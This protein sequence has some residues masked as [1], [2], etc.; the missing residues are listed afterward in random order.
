MGRSTSLDHTF[1]SNVARFIPRSMPVASMA[2]G[3]RG[4]VGVRRRKHPP[5][6]RSTSVGL[7]FE[8]A[9][10]IDDC[11]APA[12]NVRPGAVADAIPRTGYVDYVA[13]ASGCRH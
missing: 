5:A 6:H 9:N 10:V 3:A 4:W 12:V 13:A 1:Q 7:N 2:A 8:A 11:L